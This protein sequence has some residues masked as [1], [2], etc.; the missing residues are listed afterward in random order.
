MNED[1]YSPDR[2]FKVSFTSYEM[3]MSHWVDQPC[4]TQVPDDACIFSIDSDN[5][6]ARNVRWLD[7][8]T[9]ELVMLKYPGHISCTIELAV[10]TQQAQAI[11]RTASVAGSFSAVKDWVLALT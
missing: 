3:R 9:V 8:A 2:Q 5:W 1:I 10:H 4:L 6:S 11:S 7:D